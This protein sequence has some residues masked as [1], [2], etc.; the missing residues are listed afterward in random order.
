M[1]TNTGSSELADIRPESTVPSNWSVTFDPKK[2]DKLPSG[3]STRIYASVKADKKAI[4]GDYVLNL[5]TK[6]PETSGRISFRFS[7]ETAMLWGWVGVLIIL[8]ALGVVWYLFRK[9]G[10][11]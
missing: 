5:E 4:P 2:I 7:V 9:Y 3:S 10:R 8:I 6:T 1:V 11:R